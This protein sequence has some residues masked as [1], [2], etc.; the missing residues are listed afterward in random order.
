MPEYHQGKYIPQNP[1]KYIGDTSN[2]VYRSSWELRVMQW[3]DENPDV[4]RWGSEELNIPYR[5]P[6]DQQIHRY[7]PDF[8]VKFKA[9]H[10]NQVALLE[11]KP[12]SQTKPPKQTKRKRRATLIY[13]AQE[14]AVNQA[15]WEAA[16]QY[17]AQ[18]GWKFMVLTEKNL[19]VITHK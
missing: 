19:P 10:G 17:C 6:V 1:H 14:Y 9:T 5:S 7:F 4:E 15:K 18:R 11:I 3:M 2:I 8:I 13:E 12:E 16:R